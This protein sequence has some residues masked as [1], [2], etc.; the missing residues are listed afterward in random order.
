MSVF[1]CKLAMIL[2]L[3]IPSPEPIIGDWRTINDHDMT[4]EETEEHFQLLQRMHTINSC[5]NLTTMTTR[6]PLRR[7]RRRTLLLLKMKNAVGRM[8]EVHV[9][10]FIFTCWYSYLS[11]G[12]DA[13]VPCEK[14]AQSCRFMNS[15]RQIEQTDFS[16]VHNTSN[17]Q[18]IARNGITLSCLLCN[19][20]L[21]V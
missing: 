19:T 17:P 8:G 1:V 21:H 3:T 7:R 9:G 20:I 2:R 15:L 6:A 12:I 18:A 10:L 13:K 4:K 5:L 16:C 14:K 11:T